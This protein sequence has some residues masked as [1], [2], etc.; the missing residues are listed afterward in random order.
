M[1]VAAARNASEYKTMMMV[2]AFSPPPPI[3]GNEL[4]KKF[5][6]ESIVIPALL[7]GV[8]TWKGVLLFGPS[9]VGKSSLVRSVVCDIN[10]KYKERLRVNLFECRGSGIVDK[11]R[12]ESEKILRGLFE[13]ARETAG[14][15]GAGCSAPSTSQTTSLVFIDEVDSIFCGGKGDEAEHRLRVELLKHIDGI[16][17]GGRKG[18]STRVVVVGATN[19]PWDLGEALLRRFEKR[20]YVGLPVEQDRRRMLAHHLG[21]VAV[22]KNVALDDIVLQTEGMSGADIKVLCR[23]AAMGPLRRLLSP[24]SP[25]DLSKAHSQAITKDSLG[26]VT[27]ADFYRALLATKR[28]TRRADCQKLKEFDDEFGSR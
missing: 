7:P 9:G 11:Y 4:A 22:E 8:Q 19:M 28:T 14:G 18:S 15:G 25:S 17:S 3:F 2:N 10:T 13:A 16:E 20:C 12:G 23:E 24:F 5:L 27:E 26:K 1:E 21:D 6:A